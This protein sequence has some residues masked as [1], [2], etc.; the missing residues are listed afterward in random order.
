V[1]ERRRRG[2]PPLR[3]DE[4]LRSF[5]TVAVPVPVHDR[6][7]EVARMNRVSVPEFIRDLIISKLRNS[8]TQ[9]SPLR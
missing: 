7:I 2:R 1:N 8:Q 3:D 4:A 6:L 9:T 5:V